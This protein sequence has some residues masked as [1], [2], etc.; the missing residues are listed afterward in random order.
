MTT[1]EVVKMSIIVK[2]HEDNNHPDD[3][4]PPTYVMCFAI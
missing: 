2:N 1:A 4:A 3:H